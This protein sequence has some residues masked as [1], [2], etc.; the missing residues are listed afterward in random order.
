MGLDKV[1]REDKAAGSPVKADGRMGHQLLLY[2]RRQARGS[3]FI[4]P[5]TSGSFT[6]RKYQARQWL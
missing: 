5:G 1:I 4:P 3:P 6:F 2:Q